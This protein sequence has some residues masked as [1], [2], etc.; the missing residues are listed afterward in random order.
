M[1]V[2]NLLL[3]GW[4]AGLVVGRLARRF[5]FNARTNREVAA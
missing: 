5:I 1:G 4:L 2:C 3:G